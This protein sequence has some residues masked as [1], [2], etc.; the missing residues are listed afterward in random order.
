MLKSKKEIFIIRETL[1]KP[2]SWKT[3][4]VSKYIISVKVKND[5]GMEKH[6]MQEYKK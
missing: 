1:K 6:Y 2:T 4:P 3:A 5:I